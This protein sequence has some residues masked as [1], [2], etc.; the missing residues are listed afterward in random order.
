MS[1]RTK[2][3]RVAGI[4]TVALALAVG[5]SVAPAQTS[6]P[7]G[8]AVPTT[9]TTQPGSSVVV[10]LTS[11]KA[12]VKTLASAQVAGDAGA[13]KQA[14]L[15]T[16]PDEERMMSAMVD[17]AVAIADFD[18][19]MI[20]KFGPAETMKVMGDPGEILTD[21]L[22]GIDHA[23]EQVTGD[24]ATLSS[25][26]TAQGKMA[27]KRVD[28]KWR[29]YVGDLA[30]AGSPDD[31][32]RTLESANKGAT[33]YRELMADVTAG[34]LATA[35]AA[36]SA[37]VAKMSAMSGGQPPQQSP[38]TPPVPAGTGGATPGAASSPPTTMPGK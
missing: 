24:Q 10:D 38:G 12:A 19:A 33:A 25:N 7:A 21:N 9:P 28:G 8:G 18:R 17:L 6:Q 32:R 31:V 16:G 23:T 29:V 4:S 14:L 37:L 26:P 13:M 36:R 27:L 11:P 34:K 3:R 1:G 2:T 5:A 35:D 30:K 22:D 15:A 20:A